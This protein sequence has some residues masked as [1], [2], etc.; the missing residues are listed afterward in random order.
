MRHDLHLFLREAVRRPRQIA[1]LAPSS[2]ALARA[3]AEGLGP[4]SGKIVEFGP[5]TGRLTQ[6]ILDAGVPPE[7]LTLFEMNGEFVRLLERRFPRVHIIHASAQAAADLPP[8]AERVISGLP[9]LSMPPELREEIVA[10]AFA[11]L[12]P[13][14]EMFQFTYGVNLPLTD[15]QMRRQGLIARR[16]RRVWGNLPPARVLRFRRA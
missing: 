1:A 12:T 2:P 8:E 14:G 9:L 11:A 15:A 7:N 3:M 16:G 13:S 6:G 4:D 5:G 10:A